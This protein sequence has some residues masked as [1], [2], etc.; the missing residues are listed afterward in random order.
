MVEWI[1]IVIVGCGC[2]LAGWL[3][4]AQKRQKPRGQDRYVCHIC[5]D[6]DCHC[7]KQPEA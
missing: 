1:L 3:V 4:F 2:A 6:H 7:H 5:G